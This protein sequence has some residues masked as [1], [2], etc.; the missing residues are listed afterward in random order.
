MRRRM[1]AWVHLCIAR[2]LEGWAILALGRSPGWC[3][4][5]T[6]WTGDR[7]FQSLMKSMDEEEARA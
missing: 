7:M 4:R 6:A 5:F 3:R 2:P 1:C